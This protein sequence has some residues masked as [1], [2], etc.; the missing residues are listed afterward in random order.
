MK[1]KELYASPETEV[2]EIRL[3]GM[4]AA[5]GDPDVSGLGLGDPF[6]GGNTEFP[7]W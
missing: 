7:I 3:E 4:I 1:Q 5:S 2:M 6:S